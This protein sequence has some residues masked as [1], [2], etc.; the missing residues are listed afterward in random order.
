MDGGGRAMDG[1]PEASGSPAHHEF[2]QLDLDR[3]QFASTILVLF[4][5]LV[6]FFFENV[7][8]LL[9]KFLKKN[10]PQLLDI[11]QALY[12]E[13]MVIGLISIFLY[14]EEYTDIVGLITG[15]DVPSLF[16]EFIHMSIFVAV[17]LYIGIMIYLIFVAHSTMRSWSV[18][19]ALNP[20]VIERNFQSYRE[21]FNRMG[22]V[23]FA[24]SF[25]FQKKFGELRSQF[26][27][28]KIRTQFILQH[29]L[30]DQFDFGSY[31]RKCQRAVV[32]ELVE[33]H[34]HIWM[35]LLIMVSLNAVRRAMGIKLTQE[36]G[37]AYFV[38][39]GWL[40]FLASV[41]VLLKTRLIMHD[42]LAYD[43]LAF[44]PDEGLLYASRARV[45]T[46]Q[47]QSRIP[48]LPPHMSD[49]LD[50]EERAGPGFRQSQEWIN[51]TESM[52]DFVTNSVVVQPPQQKA[53]TS[54]SGALPSADSDP[55]GMPQSP[56]LSSGVRS[57]TFTPRRSS[58]ESA[59]YGA[60]SGSGQS[61]GMD[62]GSG[63]GDGQ[64]PMPKTICWPP[65]GICMET[66]L[67]V[68]VQES[69]RLLQRQQKL[70]WFGSS[71]AFQRIIQLILFAHIA[72]M[73]LYVLY[74]CDVDIDNSGLAV[75]LHITAILPTALALIVFVPRFLP[76]Y[77]IVV[78][79]GRLSKAHIIH[80]VL[81]QQ[82]ERA[83]V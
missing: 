8:D 24:L 15:D 44:N 56:A 81:K 80:M 2:D 73:T 39:I 83:R 31:L 11:V 37:A 58:G 27:Y 3:Y 48:L 76:T 42:L 49:F 36:E 55:A 5:F 35:V 28:H 45:N 61:L 67:G 38:V 46:N 52:G 1:D 9:D 21:S 79:V 51:V 7:L 63:G 62:G 17:M 78:S 54:S 72:Y 77:S 34:W 16:F 47:N 6:S 74:F 32:V 71:K 26:A 14:V 22:T 68:E 50:E 82:A 4:M 60:I 70:F 41:V 12:K 59:S 66:V 13:L 19:E 75:V 10:A 25:S 53:G 23:R 65:C 40:M 29:G 30:T 57:P 33:I 69:E 18:T 20:T 43:V 64:S